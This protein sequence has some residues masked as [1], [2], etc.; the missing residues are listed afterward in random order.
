MPDN[1]NELGQGPLQSAFQFMVTSGGLLHDE[2]GNPYQIS[3]RKELKEYLSNH[4]EAQIRGVFGGFDVE[5]NDLSIGGLKARHRA[6]Q[7]F[8]AMLNKYEDQVAKQLGIGVKAI[9]KPVGRDY[10]FSE[11]SAYGKVERGL[12]G[13]LDYGRGIFN[14]GE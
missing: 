13:I 7:L 12:G 14:S 8:S 11:E 10:L 3:T 1:F 5:D 4:G 6:R 9:T 2:A